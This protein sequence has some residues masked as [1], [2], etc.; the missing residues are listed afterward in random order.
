MDASSISDLAI[1]LSR[2]QIKEEKIEKPKKIPFILHNSFG[3]QHETNLFE[4]F[5]YSN[6][7]MRKN[8][9][10][11]ALTAIVTA[12]GL[13]NLSYNLDKPVRVNE[14]HYTQPQKYL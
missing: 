11:L 13:Y 10:A 4:R 7:S 5:N 12:V 1:G 14:V 8:L 9:T 6:Y 3:L 2:R